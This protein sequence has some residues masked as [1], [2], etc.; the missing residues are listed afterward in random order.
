M[1]DLLKRFQKAGK[2]DISA[3]LLIAFLFNY[4]PLLSSL[5]RNI[6][7]RANMKLPFAIVSVRSCWQN[8]KTIPSPQNKQTVLFVTGVCAARFYL[9]YNS[10]TLP[11]TLSL[12]AYPHRKSPIRIPLVL[13]T[14]VWGN[15]AS[16]R[17]PPFLLKDSFHTSTYL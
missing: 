2:A 1:I 6:A 7:N 14:Q 10:K 15:I 13:D 8:S 5:Q 11:L 9:L 3:V 12:Q 17:A 4:L 16:S